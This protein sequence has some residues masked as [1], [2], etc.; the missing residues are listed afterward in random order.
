MRE[1]LEGGTANDSIEEPIRKR[2]RGCV[3]LPEIDLYSL[4][5]SVVSRNFDEGVTDIES[6]DFES[7]HPGQ[8][9]GEEP[10]AGRDF[11]NGGSVRQSL[12]NGFRESSELLKVLPGIGSVPSGDP[13][14]HTQ[15]AVW[16]LDNSV[17]SDPR[18]FILLRDECGKKTESASASPIPA[19]AQG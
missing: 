4:P 6:S 14:F 1:V 15:A 13:S 18:R 10:W 7:P 5:G 2:H 8:F 9:N 11:Q 3:A 16:L 19:K 12:S 17:H